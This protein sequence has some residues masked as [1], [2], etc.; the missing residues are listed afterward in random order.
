MFINYYKDIRER[1]RINVDEIMW[2]EIRGKTKQQFDIKRKR[3]RQKKNLKNI[4]RL[5]HTKVN[6]SFI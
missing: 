6:A 3:F 2:D 1:E 4:P 5:N